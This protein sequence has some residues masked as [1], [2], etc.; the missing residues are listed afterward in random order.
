MKED[1]LK[2]YIANA[3]IFYSQEAF[4][5]F[6]LMAKNDEEALEMIREIV[7]G[8][9]LSLDADVFSNEGIWFNVNGHFRLSRGQIMPEDDNDKSIIVTEESF[10][11]DR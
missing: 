7:T 5:Q 11:N 1:T 6:K 4:A 9:G 3:T 8:P 10:Q 2:P